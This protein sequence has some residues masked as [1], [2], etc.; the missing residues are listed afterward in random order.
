VINL[1][2]ILAGLLAIGLVLI[3]TGT[4]KAGMGTPEGQGWTPWADVYVTWDGVSELG[5]WWVDLDLDGEVSDDNY[6]CDDCVGVDYDFS[7]KG[8]TMQFDEV[9]VD[10]VEAHPQTH[11]V[12][13]TDIDGDGVYDGSITARYD[14]AASLG[15]PVRMDVIE[16]TID[17]NLEGQE[18]YFKYIENEYCLPTE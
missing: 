3:F 2:K 11:H 14:Y 5:D 18:G 4:A 16:Y 7:F 12:V 8:K 9:Y 1:R 15:C 6:G 13:L 17:T 10:S